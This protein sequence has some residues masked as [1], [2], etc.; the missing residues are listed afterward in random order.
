MSVVGYIDYKLNYAS[1]NCFK[2]KVLK[3][4]ICYEVDLNEISNK[5]NIHN[6]LKTGFIFIMD[7]NEDRQVTFSQDDL[8]LS[9]GLGSRIIQ[10]DDSKHAFI[11]LDTIGR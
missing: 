11:Y 7:Y 6:E 1:C 10:N 8:Y 9:G 5:D 3:D 2:A 4:Q